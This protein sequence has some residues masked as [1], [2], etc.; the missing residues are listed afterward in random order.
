MNVT[1]RPLAVCLAVV[2][3]LAAGTAALAGPVAAAAPAAPPTGMPVGVPPAATRAEPALPAPPASVWPFG[4]TWSRTEGTGRLAGGASFWTDYVYDDHGAAFE[5]LP[6]GADSM[7]SN[8]APT[9]GV[10]SY[11][12]AAAHRNGADVFRTA[13]GLDAAGDTYWRVDWNT[14]ADATVPAAEWV[15]DDGTG[16]AT[17]A[18]PRNAGVAS[19]GAV[20][21]LFVSSRHAYLTVGGK[22]TELSPSVDLSSRSFVV[23]VPR[24]DFAP[25]GTSRLRMGSGLANAA[26][27]AFAAPTKPATAGL[28]PIPGVTPALTDNLMN[29]T[30]RTAA[31]EPPV[32]PGTDTG[33][34]VLAALAT[35]LTTQDVSGVGAD[36][37]TR[38]ITGNY[39]L[40]DHQADAL[41]AGD[42][43]D[44]SRPVTWSQL[45]ARAAT[46]E[47]LV[48]GYSN[49]WYVSS[50]GLGQGTVA[51]AT[52]PTQAAGDLAPNYLGRVQ[53]Y[54]VYVPTTY[55]GSAAAPLTWVLHSLGVNLNQY[56][57]LDPMLLQ[58]LC[59]DRGSICATTEG[60]GPDLW[61]FDDAENDFWSVWHALAGAYRLDSARTVI[62]GYSMGGWGAYKLG[63]S[64]PDLYAQAYSLE[65]P[66]TCGEEVL[67][68]ARAPAGSGHCA[69]D[70]V[71]VPVLPSAR[72][73]PYT[74]TAGAA[75]E[76]VP[77]TSTTESVATLDGLGYRY[78][79]FLY[80]T[81]E[82]LSYATQDRFG[83]V[84]DTIGRGTKTVNPGHV[85]YAWIPDTTS[86]A[87]GIGA[88]TAYWASGL[89]AR[90]TTPGQVASVD[91]TSA[92]RPDPAITLTR[93]APTPLT[94]PVPG[95]E[96]S[97]GWTLGARAAPRDALTLRLT[98]VAALSVDAVRAGLTCPT[99]TATTDGPSAL[100]VTGLRTGRTVLALPAG[101]S[102]HATCAAGTSGRAPTPSAGAVGA[103][104]ALAF[105]GGSPATGLAALALLSAGAAAAVFRRRR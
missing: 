18:W 67:S 60:Y 63:L 62:G 47:P 95:V 43:S 16:T 3:A 1:N 45:A 46:P 96:T 30:F 29:V 48:H 93:P 10:Y 21:S 74:I 92:G 79:F 84:L 23:R 25:T 19:T 99:V 2:A 89:A 12:T 32:Y 49:R 69:D 37:L 5:G 78:H 83:P 44:F 100:T 36:G 64:H 58:Q 15:W 80:P 56:G 22:T 87:L 24:A 28:P 27:T 55:T 50:L 8:L 14:L 57:A 71:S 105:T 104:G 90:S 77:V 6:V 53:P 38:S 81:V 59:Q 39:W 98:D 73:L 66:P 9:Q 40:E 17:A 26:G 51:N 34:A 94:S 31:Q 35:L 65:G 70:G 7:I 91:A 54:A 86:S 75:D 97:L 85:T 33:S 101:T 42:V 4:E 103:S 61:Y 11:P 88:T 68:G 41:E 13:V 102:T 52:S 72:W 76:L 20:D 82:H